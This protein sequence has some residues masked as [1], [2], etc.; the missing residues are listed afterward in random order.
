MLHKVILTEHR[1]YLMGFLRGI[2]N[3]CQSYR[4]TRQSF[5]YSK[6]QHVRRIYIEKTKYVVHNEQLSFI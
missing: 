5:E 4:E 1:L 6:I 3:L 2:Y